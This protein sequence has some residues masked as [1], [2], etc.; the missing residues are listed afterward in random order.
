[1]KLLFK[2]FA[3]VAGLVAGFLG[4]KL[5]EFLWGLVD[6]EEPPKPST[7]DAATGKVVAAA[8]IEG[9]AFAGTRALVSRQA[10]A[11]FHHLTGVWPGEKKPDPSVSS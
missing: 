5:F 7:Q 9:L 4:K 2:P 11:T 10:A 6:K 3:L 8:A 1:M